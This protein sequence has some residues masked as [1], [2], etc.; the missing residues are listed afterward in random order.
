M[1]R[2]E[3]LA[4]LEKELS[5]LP[6]KDFQEAMDYFIEYFDEAGS[7]NE[8]DIIEELGT[9]HE[10]ARDI[11]A[12]VLGKEQGSEE[13]RTIET[14][15]IP[16]SG[17]EIALWIALIIM[18]SPVLFT[19]ALIALGV[20]FTFGAIV[21]AALSFVL[22]LIITLAALLFTGFVLSASAILVAFVTLGES[23]TLFNNSWPAMTLGIGGFF[24]AIG[25]S[26]LLFLASLYL[27]KLYG[28]FLM[29]FGKWLS[30]TLAD[31]WKKRK[32][33]YKA[34]SNLISKLKWRKSHEN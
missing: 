32:H 4:L 21:I 11:L 10:A 20:L 27:S 31:F 26:V 23:L 5:A 33:L 28:R 17:K 22:G 3:Y 14:S 19:I 7:E 8:A 12:N 6:K 29:A 15:K 9:P 25:V 16:R 24:L 34:I 30:K 18:A 2:T 13:A 1:T